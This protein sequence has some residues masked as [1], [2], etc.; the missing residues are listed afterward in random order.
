VDRRAF[1]GTLTGGLLAA[2]LAAQAQGTGKVYRVGVVLEGGPYLTAIEGLKDGLKGLGFEEG[3]Q[4][5]LHIRDVKGDPAAVA[6][7][8]RHLE[9]DKVDV[10]YAIST[11]VTKA[12]QQATVSVP[13]VFYAGDDPVSAGLVKTLAKPGGRFTGVHSRAVLSSLMGKRFALLK[14]MV[15]KVQRVLEFHD[16]RSPV[17]RDRAEVVRAEARQ[18]GIELVSQ[19]VRSV[20]ELREQMG[21]LR[22]GEADGLFVWD[23]LAISQTQFIVD[24]A[25]MRKLPTMFSERTSVA[26]G[27]LASYGTSYY[28]VGQLAANY[29]HRVLLGTN[30]ADLP[31]ERSDRF[32]LVINLRTAKALGLTIPP[33]LLQRADQVIE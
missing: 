32:E 7:A 20:D 27:G 25:K 29:I 28:L 1:L 3:K 2:P 17:A 14:E 5:T 10:I 23:A 4:Y 12:V 22:I 24:V 16:Q 19:P 15:P 18:L 31:V 8:A 11:T 9:R 30:P 21:R 26:A 6:E 33:S 13:V